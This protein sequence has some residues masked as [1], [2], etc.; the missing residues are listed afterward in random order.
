MGVQKK[1]LKPGNGV[2]RPQKGDSVTMEYTGWLYD[3]NKPEN[4][5]KGSK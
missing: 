3:A 2:D 4:D 1:I 5:Y